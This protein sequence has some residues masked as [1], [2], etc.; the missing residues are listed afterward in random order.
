MIRQHL[1]GGARA[2]VQVDVV[3]ALADKMGTFD[4]KKPETYL[5][6]A[7]RAYTGHVAAVLQHVEMAG[8]PAA[9]GRGDLA[10]SVEVVALAEHTGTFLDTVASSFAESRWMFEK[11]LAMRKQLGGGE[12]SAEVA[13]CYNRIGCNCSS[14][15]EFA[16]ALEQFHRALGTNV[17]P[18]ARVCGDDS[19]NVADTKC[20]IAGV[21]ERQ[22]SLEAARELL[23]ELAEIS[24]LRIFT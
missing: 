18:R 9:G 20:N 7:C 4:E 16:N 23:L 6:C 5:A 17:G 8:V 12:E 3:A 14:L 21:H 10:A 19:Q 13:F 15:Y 22:G 1:M 11:A 2:E 24:A